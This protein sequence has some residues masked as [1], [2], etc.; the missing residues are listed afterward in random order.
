MVKQQTLRKTGEKRTADEITATALASVY[1]VIR[2]AGNNIE[3]TAFAHVC[4]DLGFKIIELERPMVPDQYCELCAF[5]AGC[6]RV[7]P[8]PRGYDKIGE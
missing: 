3:H 7:A 8:C 2:R 5:V 1:G 4:A 6:A